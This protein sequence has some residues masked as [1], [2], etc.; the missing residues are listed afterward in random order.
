MPPDPSRRDDFDVCPHCWH[1]N[2]PMARICLRCR[3]DMTLLLQESGGQQWAAPVQSPVP[4]R[5]GSR[6]SRTQRAVILGFVV[7]FGVAQLVAAFAPRISPH[8]PPAVPGGR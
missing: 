7:L 8:L 6:L 1:V 2:G 4:V 5:G 3:A